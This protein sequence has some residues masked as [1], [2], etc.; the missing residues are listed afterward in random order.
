MAQATSTLL[1]ANEHQ[2]LA[3]LR[4][5]PDGMLKTSLETFLVELTTFLSNPGCAGI[6]ADGIPCGSAAAD[7]EEC[8]M[9]ERMMST[10][11]S[12]I[13]QH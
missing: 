7:C 3:A 2:L 10:L 8:L 9:L 5:I 13:P 1:S 12:T 4:E 6:Q 11:K